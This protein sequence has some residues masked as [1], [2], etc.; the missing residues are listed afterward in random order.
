[1]K[2]PLILAATIFASAPACAAEREPQINIIFSAENAT[3]IAWTK[4]AGNKFL[5][6]QAYEV[7]ARGF[8]SGYNYSTP[9]RQVKAE[10]FP[11]GEDFNQYF[12][13]F[14]RDHPRQSFVAGAIQLVEQLAEANATA[15]PAPLRK[16]PPAPAPAAK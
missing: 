4:S 8:V 1:M 6:S 10:A 12:D 7:W 5:R 2:A 14:C 11:S 13:Q 9:R 3:C 16:P 15:K